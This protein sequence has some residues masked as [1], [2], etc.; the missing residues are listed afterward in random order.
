MEL[1]HYADQSF[2]LDRSRVYEQQRRPDTFDKPFGLW[3][4][5]TG[6][7]DWASWCN[8][9]EF[10]LGCLQVKHRVTL[11]PTANV[12]YLSSV[13]ELDSFH[14]MFRFETDF[15]RECNSGPA[16]WPI[17]W[18]TVIGKYDGIIIAPYIWERR[19]MSWYYGWDCASGCIWNLDAIESFEMEKSK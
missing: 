15:D 6:E 7:D 3:V 1:I 19:I 17:D 9:E 12:L 8:S 18:N 16:F 5:V 10:R 11:N 13:A 2:E 4:S 14:E